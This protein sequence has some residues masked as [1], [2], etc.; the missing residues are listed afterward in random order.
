M[1]KIHIESIE[2]RLLRSPGVV[3]LAYGLLGRS[4]TM[5]FC[6]HEVAG[7]TTLDSELLAELAGCL[8]TAG[9]ASEPA[10]RLR[11]G[12]AKRRRPPVS[13]DDL[14]AMV[15]ALDASPQPTGEWSPAREVL[16]DALL[17]RLAGDIS[18]TSLRRYASGARETPDDVAWRLHVVARLLASLLGSYNSYGVRRWFERRRTALQGMTPAETLHVARD[19]DDEQLMRVLALADDLIGAGAAG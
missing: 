19:E 16:G 13:A 10:A 11:A 2:P 14:R 12:V 3:R 5:G 17:A 15:Q 6:P 9:I 4:Q 1:V 18:L 8:Q 7:R